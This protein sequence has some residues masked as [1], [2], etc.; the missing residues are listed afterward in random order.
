MGISVFIADFLA[1]AINKK[2]INETSNAWETYLVD[3]KMEKSP[4]NLDI[5]RI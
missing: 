1:K 4:S 5:V 2:E 3:D